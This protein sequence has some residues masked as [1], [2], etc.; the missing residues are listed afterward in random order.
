[1]FKCRVG[2]APLNVAVGLSR[3]GE[4]AVFMGSVGDDWLGKNTLAYLQQKKIN[5]RVSLSPDFPTR[6]SVVFHDANRQRAFSFRSGAA[7]EN[8]I[9]LDRFAAIGSERFGV[10][11]RQAPSRPKGSAARIRCL[12]K[13]KLKNS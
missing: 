7:A 6:I 12:Q 3:L 5:H 13:M 4:D 2:G 11:T 8:S 10:P 9:P 1:M